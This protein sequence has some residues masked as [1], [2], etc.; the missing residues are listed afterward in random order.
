MQ[1]MLCFLLCSL[2]R[3]LPGRQLSDRC[4]VR[5]RGTAGSHCLLPLSMRLIAV[6]L[7]DLP[8]QGLRSRAGL[9]SLLCCFLLPRKP[10]IR[11]Q[12]RRHPSKPLI[13]ITQ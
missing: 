11:L 9:V 13:L 3:L 7:A 8:L 10:L 6:Q 4:V 12:A 5:R 1:R 2:C